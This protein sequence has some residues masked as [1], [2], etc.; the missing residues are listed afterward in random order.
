VKA[1]KYADARAI[2]LTKIKKVSRMKTKSRLYGNV[3]IDY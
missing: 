2:Q 1:T 3:L